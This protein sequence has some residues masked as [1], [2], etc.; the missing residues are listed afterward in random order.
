MSE[1]ISIQ[2]GEYGRRVV[3]HSEWSGRLLEDMAK[4]AVV[5]LEL[6]IAKGW[7]GNDL[8]F[9]GDLTGLL[10]FEIF[11]FGIRNIE[12]VH[13]LVGLRRLGLTTYCSTAIDFSAFR[14]LE[15]CSFEW[16][17]NATSLFSCL[18]LRNLFI[19]RYPGRNVTPV[20][21][22][23][24][25][26]S[27]AILNAPVEN[28]EGLNLLK[29]LRTL[30]MGNL[31]RLMSLRGIEGLT[32]LEELTIQSCRGVISIEEVASLHRLRK[33][34][35]SNDGRVESLAPLDRLAALESVVFDESTNI[36]DG[37]L[38]PLVRQKHLS[39]LSFQNRTHYS[40][41]REDFAAYR[42]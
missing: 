2:D 39:N 21:Q 5:E 7:R 3:L 29:K 28:L 8:S 25:L 32:E 40:H 16:R 23:V 17:P 37:D 12:A 13:C 27:L 6:N 31:K 11:D 1:E 10:A 14:Q 41:R 38:S 36:V 20:T 34:H 19:N 24:N 42:R 18:T 35:L 9:L 4:N 15:S 26:E 22:L 33:L 30:R